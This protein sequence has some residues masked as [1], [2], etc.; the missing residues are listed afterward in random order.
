MDHTD[1]YFL[2]SSDHSRL[3][4]VSQLLD[5]D[6][7]STWHCTITISLSAKNKLGFIDGTI[8]PLFEKYP[9]YP[10]WCH[11]ND[12]VMAWLLNALTP[13]LANSVIHADAPAEV[14]S[15]LQDRFSL[16]NL[17]HVF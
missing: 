17:T 8:K 4:I 6:N 12:M 11:C 7:Y 9:K 1:P 5:G 14:W 15:D 16:G 2:K 10:L 13:T 3:V